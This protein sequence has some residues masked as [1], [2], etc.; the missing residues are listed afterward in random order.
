MST[1]EFFKSLIDASEKA[2][3]IARICRSNQRLFELLIQEK[4]DDEAN[5]RFFRD[6]KTLADVVI[7]ETIRADVGRKFPAIRDNI[8][9]EENSKF[10]NALGESVMVEIG[11]DAAATKSMLLKVLD[12]NEVAADALTQ[13]IHRTDVA[14][15][16]DVCLPDIIDEQLDFGKLGIWI[17][18]IDGTQ[19]YIDGHF[20]ESPLANIDRS[21]LRCATVLIGVYDKCSN[22]PLF[23]VINQPFFE[24]KSDGTYGS[25]VFWGAAINKL[26]INNIASCKENDNSKIAIISAAESRKQTL[27]SA[28]Y[29]TVAANGAGYKILKVIENHANI[30]FLTKGT[31]YKWDTCAGQAI[32]NSLGGD[33]IDLT[34]SIKQKRPVSLT[35]KDDESKSNQNGLIAYRKV[36]HLINLIPSFL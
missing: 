13:E 29:Q 16:D 5:P 14:I 7:Q 11:D 31:T 22:K 6:F 30:Y 28:G 36:D 12:G 21:G 32:L 17:D 25:K 35:Y 33:I 34:A 10:E 9:G 26:H 24:C 15:G 3:N 1:R 8:C 2:A 20:V 27:E 18:P 23:G 4:S 19:E